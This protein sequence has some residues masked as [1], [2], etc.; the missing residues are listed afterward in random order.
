MRVIPDAPVR[1]IAVH[2]SDAYHTEHTVNDT[3]GAIHCTSISEGTRPVP[4]GYWITVPPQLATVFTASGTMT[5]AVPPAGQ[6]CRY[7]LIGN[8][9]LL[10][11]LLT[12]VTVTAPVS[13]ILRMTIPGGFMA[14]QGHT[15][16]LL[17]SENAAA[18]VL[19]IVRVLPLASTVEFIRFDLA[20]FTAEVANTTITGQL[21]FEVR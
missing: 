16:P 20:N 12:N 4:M 15:A 21:A 18:Y 5:W 19:G 8:T 14:V 3:H 9:M 13:N 7:M 6:L 2:V 10:S 11:V 17:I 1:D